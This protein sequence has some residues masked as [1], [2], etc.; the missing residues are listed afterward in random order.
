MYEE[1][2]VRGQKHRE[3]NSKVSYGTL[4]ESGR[5][6]TYFIFQYTQKVAHDIMLY[7]YYFVKKLY[8]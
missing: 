5:R 2:N 7:R 1:N 3:K 4:G 6:H 8:T